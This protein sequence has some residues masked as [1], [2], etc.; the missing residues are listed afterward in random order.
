M[1]SKVYETKISKSSKGILF[2]LINNVLMEEHR[3]RYKAICPSSD[4]YIIEFPHLEIPK[5]AKHIKPH[6]EIYT[7]S[8]LKEKLM[9]MSLK[10]GGNF[11][12]LSMFLNENSD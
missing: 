11:K 6:Y 1:V 5:T 4:F 3:V 12:H 10:F 8:N 7:L 2:Y 9:G